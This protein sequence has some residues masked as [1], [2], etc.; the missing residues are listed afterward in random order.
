VF[1]RPDVTRLK[2]SGDVGGLIKA[3]G[4]RKDEHG[5]ADPARAL[6]EIGDQRA[7]GPLESL[8]RQDMPRPNRAAIDSIGKIGG[9]AA[10]DV[11]L[12]LFT[13][14]HPAP[15]QRKIYITARW[16]RQ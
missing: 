12:G 7:V 3:L 2:S 9:P 8:I 10:A 11:L 15:R 1:R 5:Q 13:G 16:R 14:S 4:Y 6:G